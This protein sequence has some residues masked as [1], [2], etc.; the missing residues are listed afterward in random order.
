MDVELVAL[1]TVQEM[2]PNYGLVKQLTTKLSEADYTAWLA[3]MVPHHYAQVVAKENG[4]TIGLSGFWIGHKLY[5]GKY[6]EIDNF[7]VDPAHRSRG[8]GELLV[9]WLE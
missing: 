7:V 2:L 4:E 9:R 5:C 6:L 8:V 3:R 1:H